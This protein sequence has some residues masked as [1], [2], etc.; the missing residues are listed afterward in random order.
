MIMEK[1]NKTAGDKGRNGQARPG[2]AHAPIH[3][4]CGVLR[5]EEEGQVGKR[6]EE[7]VS[8]PGTVLCGPDVCLCCARQS[9]AGLTS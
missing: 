7:T 1:N 3:W 4:A 9:R 8:C 2:R 6:H 5:Q